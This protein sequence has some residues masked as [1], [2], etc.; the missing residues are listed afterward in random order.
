MSAA[1]RFEIVQEDVLAALRL[2]DDVSGRAVTDAV[3]LQAPGMVLRRK[4]SG[5]LLVMSAAPPA[6]GGDGHPIDLR[7]LGGAFMPRRFV[8]HLPRDAD[9]A[10][11]QAAGSLFQPALVRLLPAPGYPL[12]ANLAALRVTVRRA[13]DQARIGNALVRL[14]PA[15]ATLAKARAL[16][17]A[18]GEALLVLSGVPLSS[19]G[20]GATVLGD[21]G[22]AL[23]V[24][25]DP[26]VATFTADA[27]LDA[28]RAAADARST[29]FADPDDIE[30]R[31][32]AAAPAGTPVRIAA[33]A[34]G[35]A[36]LPWVPA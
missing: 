22:A 6:G 20:P 24:L 32:G 35:L 21:V 15:L 33:G 27:D 23:D 28:A 31:L 7:P 34:V 3:L 25:V 26:A 16:T 12:G 13:T 9:P 4:R 29:G 14:A 11:A 19:P 36:V 1:L 18:A 8:L 17:D 30:A 2:V 5:D 10:H